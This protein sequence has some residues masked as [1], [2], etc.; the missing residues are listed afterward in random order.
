MGILIGPAFA[1]SFLA[2]LGPAAWIA[3]R[4]N[5]KALLVGAVLLWSG[6]TIASA[7]APTFT[8]LVLCRGGVGIGE[9]V[10]VPVALSMIGDLFDLDRRPAPA[11]IFIASQTFGSAASFVLVA[12]ILDM[13]HLVPAF[14]SLSGGAPPWRIV[15]FLAGV[16]GVVLALL[17]LFTV[18]EPIRAA[19]RSAD[20]AASRSA[21]QPSVDTDRRARLLAIRFYLPHLLAVNVV[22][23]MA[24]VALSW[25]PVFLTRQ[26]GLPIST[27]GYLF[28]AVSFLTVLGPLLFSFIVGRRAVKGD[29]TVLMRLILLSLPIALVSLSF[30]LS[31]AYL[32]AIIVALAM[33]L[34][35]TTGIGSSGS[36]VI[37]T[38]GGT[39]VRGRLTGFHLLLQSILGLTI[40]P[41][42]VPFLSDNF[43]HGDL[44]ASMLATAFVIFPISLALFVTARRPYIEIVEDLAGDQDRRR[45]PYRAQVAPDC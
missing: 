32:P 30:A 18:R 23:M 29:R 14:S 35:L 36:L 8:V 37:A 16:P 5:R 45:A 20:L 1:L 17:I 3:D 22:G 19:A 21:K 42:I 38:I 2:A 28:G 13:V 15:L 9:A 41:V 31:L 7:F 40:A 43:F 4:G 11:G 10:L 33:G 25:F 26:H 39:Q 44:G 34:V 24:Y 12:L 27:V 6:L